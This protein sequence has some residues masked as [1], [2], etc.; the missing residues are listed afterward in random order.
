[1]FL[2]LFAL[3]IMVSEIISR[4]FTDSLLSD[5]RFLLSGKR[6]NLIESGV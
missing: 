5:S 1:M 2:N 6:L 3:E 4:G